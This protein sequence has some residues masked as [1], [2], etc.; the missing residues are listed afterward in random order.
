M[1]RVSTVGEVSASI[2]NEL[3]QP[4]GAIANNAGACLG[5]LS[6]A[7]PELDEVRGALS[8]IVGDA[9]RASAIIERVRGMA[10]RSEPERI[11]IRLSDLVREVVAL[12]AA[13]AA[14]RRVAIRTDVPDDLPLVLGDRVQLQQVLLNLVLNGMDAMSGVNEAD[15]TLEIRGSSSELE[16]QPAA[17]ISVQD[18]GV[19]LRAE[20]ADRLFQPFYTTKA[21]HGSR[22]GDQSLIIEAHRGPVGRAQSGTRRDLPFALPETS[23][24]RRPTTPALSSSPTW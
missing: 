10:R 9:E 17:R 1:T 19:G 8:D 2:A 16:G 21:R 12:A 20:Q 7:D 5:L 3:N 23:S 24:R 13:E 14:A 6:G 18:R 22:S 11:P 4:L 15:R